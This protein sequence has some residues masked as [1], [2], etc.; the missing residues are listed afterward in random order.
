MLS[1]DFSVS[2]P[3]AKVSR[4]PTPWFYG[5]GADIRYVSIGFQGWFGNFGPR[6][7]CRQPNVY[8]GQNKGFEPYTLNGPLLLQLLAKC[9]EILRI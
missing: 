6:G 4:G 1:D 5:L 3:T 7:S 2:Q 8:L 9:F